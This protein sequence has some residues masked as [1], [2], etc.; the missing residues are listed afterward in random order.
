LVDGGG[1]GQTL[2]SLT[3][4]PDNDVLLVDLNSQSTKDFTVRGIFS[5]GSSVDYTRKAVWSVDNSTTGAFQ[6]PTFVSAILTANNVAF[7]KVYAKVTNDDGSQLASVAQLTVV[8]LRQSGNSQD[9]FFNLPYMINPQTQT[10][11]FTTQVQSLD[12]FF[13]VDT[14]GSMGGEIQQ[15]T[16]SLQTTIIPNVKASAAK[17][18]WFG[19]GAQDDWPTGGY[20]QPGCDGPHDQPLILIQ[21]MTA[22]IMAAQNAVTQLMHNGAPAGCGDDIPEGQMEELYQ[23]ATGSGQMNANCDIPPNHTGIGGVGFRDGALPVVVPVSDAVFHSI[24]DAMPYTCFGSSVAYGSDVSPYGHTR[25]QVATALNQICAKVVGISA[26]NGQ[27]EGC[28]S[29]NDMIYF[30]NATGA[31]VPPE[32]WDIPMRPANCATGQCCTGEA[33]VGEMP[34]MAGLCPL[35]FKIPMDGTGI[36]D[37]V[38]A[39]IAQLARFASFSVVT[40]VIG[41][42]TDEEG[43]MLPA[44]DTTANFLQSITPLDALPP[45]PPP[46]IPTP[47][48]MGNGFVNV[49]PGSLVRFTVTAT[50]TIQPATTWPQVFHATIRIR[51]GGCADLDSRDVIILIP[52][53]ALTPG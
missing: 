49:V 47:L 4:M 31:V 9:F 50:N 37:Q 19:V 42:T 41:Q 35:V 15:L 21:P 3:I 24:G 25:T 44:G 16:N 8:W 33:G 7:T 32:A 52:P 40:D 18:A 51:A 11:T 53:T 14:T 48:I 20:G 6:G 34:N 17:S 39:G 30:A 46:T 36:G 22:D 13:G 26:R 5:D 29:T 12:V 38:T 28:E 10:L 23:I 1:A 2:V 45:P 27:E 43:D